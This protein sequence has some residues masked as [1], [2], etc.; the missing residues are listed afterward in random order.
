YTAAV[1][2]RRPRAANTNIEWRHPIIESELLR[3]GTQHDF[4]DV[5][6]AWFIDGVGNGAGHGV[7]RNGLFV[8]LLHELAAFLV[9]AAMLQFRIDRTRFDGGGTDRAAD[10]MAQAFGNGAYRKLGAAVD[11]TSRAEDLDA[12]HGSDVDEVAAALFLEDGQCGGDTVQH[13]F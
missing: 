4:V 11:S 13:A 7:R 8:E 3:G 5:H 6:I 10:L 9:R 1:Y 12:G 2:R